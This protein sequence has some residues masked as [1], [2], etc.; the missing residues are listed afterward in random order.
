MTP[1]ERVAVLLDRQLCRILDKGV[2]VLG[3]DGVPLKD[4]EGKPVRR[5]AGT[6]VLSVAL[7]RIEQHRTS[8]ETN[9]AFGQPP[10]GYE[11]PARRAG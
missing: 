9:L 6:D 8:R 7:R 4:D 10:P 3:K 2:Q 5:E 1:G 11:P